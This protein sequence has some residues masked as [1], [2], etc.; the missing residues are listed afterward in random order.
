M[1]HNETT[2]FYQTQLR[3][4]LANVK[5]IVVLLE[6]RDDKLAKDIVK[7]LKQAGYEL[8]ASLARIAK[9]PYLALS[10]DRSKS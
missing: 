3:L 1:K 6:K 7:S 10:P 4:A 8:E 5:T 9:L 2:W